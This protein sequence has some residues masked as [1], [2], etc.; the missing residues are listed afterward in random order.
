M[1]LYLSLSPPLFLC[2]FLSSNNL[3]PGSS[4]RECFLLLLGPFL[5]ALS[6]SVLNNPE[7]VRSVSVLL[8]SSALQRLTC[9]HIVI[10]ELL[11][12]YQPLHGVVVGEERHQV[13]QHEPLAV[14]EQIFG[15]IN[16]KF[17]IGIY[18]NIQDFIAMHEVPCIFISIFF[19]EDKVFIMIL[20]RLGVCRALRP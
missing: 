4:H 3:S 2:V 6:C 8:R 20:L 17:V 1:H 15:R 14:C 9:Y 5:L 7:D 18:F 13:L 16:L 19:M 10:L 12:K 11:A